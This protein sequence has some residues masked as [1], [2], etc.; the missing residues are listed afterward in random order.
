MGL[1][2]PEY[3]RKHPGELWG[4]PWRGRSSAFWLNK[5]WTI[6]HGYRWRQVGQS[7]IPGRLNLW[8]KLAAMRDV[9]ED[10]SCHVSL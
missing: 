1:E 4:D 7:S 6:R 9:A 3:L 10:E 5:L 2:N 8:S